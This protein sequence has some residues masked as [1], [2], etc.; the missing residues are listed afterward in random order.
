MFSFYAIWFGLDRIYTF[1]VSYLF[2]MVVLHLGYMNAVFTSPLLGLCLSKAPLNVALR[3]CWAMLLAFLLADSSFPPVSSQCVSVL[4]GASSSLWQPHCPVSRTEREL[5]SSSRHHC[6]SRCQSLTSN[7]MENIA[8][9]PTLLP[10]LLTLEH[11]AQAW[12]V[13]FWKLFG[14]KKQTQGSAVRWGCDLSPLETWVPRL[15]RGWWSLTSQHQVF[16][17]ATQPHGIWE[18]HYIDPN[19]ESAVKCADTGLWEI[20]CHFPAF[21]SSQIQ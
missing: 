13:S 11:Q 6:G 14:N 5:L 12:S 16:F 15:S 9:P 8:S 17:N 20:I 18:Q 1:G 10:S 3:N 2:L 21:P 7:C 19:E 4:R